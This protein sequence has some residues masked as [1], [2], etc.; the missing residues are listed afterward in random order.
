[1]KQLPLKTQH[2]KAKTKQLCLKSW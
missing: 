1:M 2:G